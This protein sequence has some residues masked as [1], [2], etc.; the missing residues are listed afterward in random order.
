M[1][2]I[3]SLRKSGQMLSENIQV[4][5]LPDLLDLLVITTTQMHHNLMW[6]K[7]TDI[8]VIRDTRKDVQLIQ[9]A[10]LKKK[11]VNSVSLAM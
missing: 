1:K 10:I 2:M 11:S 6:Q 3:L 4:L 9:S 7:E 8:T 5:S